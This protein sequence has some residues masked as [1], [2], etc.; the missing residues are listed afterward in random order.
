[1]KSIFKYK[2]YESGYTELSEKSNSFQEVPATK[3]RFLFWNS[4]CS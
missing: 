1:M 2:W 3:K 4:R